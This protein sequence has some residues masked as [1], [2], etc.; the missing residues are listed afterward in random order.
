MSAI[1][2]ELLTFPQRVGG[3]IRLRTFGDEHFS[4]LE[5]EEGFTAL[6]DAAVGAYC[7][8]QLAGNQLQSSGVKLNQ[9]VPA[10]IVR[11][12]RPLRDTSVPPPTR[13][14]ARLP[15]GARAAPQVMRAF[16]PN[17]GLLDGRRL[18]VGNVRGLTILV[19]FQD[20]Q[21]ATTVADVDAL[22]N[23]VNYT[24]NGNKGSVRE[25]FAKMSTGKLN[26]S[27]VVVGPFTLSRVREFYTTT[28]LVEEAVQLAVANGVNLAQFD[29]RN[30]NIVD[31]L[32]V[33]YAGQS[34]YQG[35]LWPHN[36]GL[37][38]QFGATR[39][40]DYLL[41]GL[42]RDANDLSIG[43]ICHENGHLLCRFPDMYDYGDRDGDVLPSSGIGH[44]CLMGAGN[45]L[46]DG[47]RP[48]PV[49]AYLRELAGWCDTVVSL[50]AGGAFDIVQGA[51]NTVYKFRTGKANE[52]FILE[53]RSRMGVDSDVPANG[54]AVYHCDV[55]GSNEH[56][57]GT[58]DKHFQCALLQADGRR[59]LESNANRGDASDLFAA[60]DGV[61]LSSASVPHTREWDG[62]DS[63]L[64]VSNISVP[65]PTIS[66]LV[67]ARPPAANDTDQK[68]V[69][70]RIPD[71]DRGG[72][73]SVIDIS[74]PG[75]VAELSVTVGI[76]HPYTGDLVV[77]LMSPT[78]RR[79][80]LHV[81]EGFNTANL[82]KTYT[83]ATLGQ[84]ANLVGQ[85][86]QGAWMLMVADRAEQDQGTFDNWALTVKTQ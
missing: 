69:N 37:N 27:N 24:R 43:T 48:A 84:L 63:T 31:A 20:V 66:V 1:F 50:N 67:G 13:P 83:S 6:Y 70:A 17:Q 22:L 47:K 61:A 62:R 49:C 81:R 56:Q 76:T 9:A 77:E 53:N 57:N 52:Y 26:Y 12:L 23:G 75:I 59:D 42:G 45:H 16:A 41:T 32:N 86:A 82:N 10:G 51:Y 38:Q 28:L 79:A 21:S 3:E 25:Y 34:V 39:V 15:A 35:A 14:A 58:A 64:V 65:G 72:V 5:T 74:T 60:V 78:G 4:R 30:E 33:L 85:P 36:S 19:N 73:N 7:Y 54:L 29:S 18:S 55:L 8:A 80:L 68:Q 44:Y 46:G 2:G 71:N 40:G 11:H